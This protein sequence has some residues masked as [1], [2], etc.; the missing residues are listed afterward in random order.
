MAV[1]L[2]GPPGAFWSVSYSTGT[3]SIPVGAFGTIYLDPAKT[4]HLALGAVGPDGTD[5]FFVTVPAVPALIGLVIHEQA[6]IDDRFSNLETQTI[7]GL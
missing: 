2:H 7:T 1:D 3:A 6:F 4:F 5:T